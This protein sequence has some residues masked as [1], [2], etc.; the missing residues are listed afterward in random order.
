M[1]EKKYIKDQLRRIFTIVRMGVSDEI[2][3]QE[4][5]NQFIAEEAQKMQRQI[6]SMSEGEF[7]TFCLQQLLDGVK[8]LRNKLE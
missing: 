8:E 6:D 5:I 7:M 1:D 3:T 4:E 2:F